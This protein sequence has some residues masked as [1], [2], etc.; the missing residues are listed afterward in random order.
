M[1]IG[2][3]T[4][5]YLPSVHGVTISI[6][7]LRKNLEKLGHKVFVFAPAHPN[8]KDKNPNVFRFKSIRAFSKSDTYFALPFLPQKKQ[9]KEILDLKLDIC[10]AHSPFNM[11][12]F[13][14]YISSHQDIPLVYTHHTLYSAYAKFYLKES[15][16]TPYLAR[17]WSTWFSNL[18]DLVIA[19]SPKIKKMLKEYGVKKKIEILPTGIDTDIFK[20]NRKSR[21]KLR[22]EL[23]LPPDAK[24]LIYAG[25]I[26]E[27]KNILFLV[28]SFAELKKK[29]ENV[30]LLLIGPALPTN[31]YV[32]KL[33]EEIEKEKIEK[34]VIFTGSIPHKKMPFYYQGSDV[35]LFASLTDTQGIVILEAEACGLP[36]VAL[37]DDAF[38]N[39]VEN[40]K[41]CFLVRKPDPKSFAKRILEIID[42][43]SLWEKFSHKSHQIAQSFSEEKQT[44]KLLE[45]YKSLL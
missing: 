11:G 26:V 34:Y 18:S 43:P 29:R 28:K 30:Y 24:I 4:D 44:K 7:T 17:V 9:L 25:R 3:F 38:T 1:K 23:K 32:K 15:L 22:K 16:I 19:P 6:E 37:K 27:E 31:P 8:Y 21:E 10:H 45:I 39:L 13:G 35:F 2:F 42:N 33:K 12:F 41:N 14:K 36:I 20:I 40:K 5:G